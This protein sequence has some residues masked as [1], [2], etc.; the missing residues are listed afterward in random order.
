MVIGFLS[1]IACL[2]ITGCNGFLL[3]IA[4]LSVFQLWAEKTLSIVCEQL[5]ANEA[6]IN[7]IYRIQFSGTFK[8]SELENHTTSTP[9]Y[10]LCQT[11][12]GLFVCKHLL[13]VYS[14]FP[15][16]LYNEKHFIAK[17]YKHKCFDKSKL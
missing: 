9:Y 5:H 16:K 8:V 4:L 2:L 10:Q 15:L 11:N 14:C 17:H 6:E 1:T 3:L 12:F 13:G 7:S